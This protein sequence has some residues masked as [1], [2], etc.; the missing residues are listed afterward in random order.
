MPGCARAIFQFAGRG[1]NRDDPLGELI[2]EVNLLSD[3]LHRERLGALEASALLRTVISELD[4]NIFSFDQDLRLRLVN[5][6]GERL[7]DQPAERLLGRHAAELGLAECLAHEGARTLAM[8][9]AGQGAAPATRWEAQH[10]RFR[11]QGVAQH[12]LVLSDLSRALREEERQ[13]WQRLVRVLGHELNNSL[14]PIKSIAASLGALLVREPL[15]GDWRTDTQRG[16]E[17]IGSRAEALGRFMTAYAKLARLPRPELRSIKISP[18]L[19][20]IVALETR[21]PLILTPGQEVTVQADEGQ[22]EQLLIN[23]IRNA[24]E[25]TLEAERTAVFVRWHVSWDA[26]VESRRERSRVLEVQ[27]EDEGHGVGD[28][29][30]LFV[31]FFTTKPGGSGIGLVLSRQ[32]A[33]AHG[34]S[35]TLTDKPAS[36]GCIARL[37][38]PLS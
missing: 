4:V 1:A 21:L 30:N 13:A 5:R 29:A 28:T 16:L 2:A 7:L 27:I 26:G 20:R 8:R 24:V 33:E 23:L 14:T 12:L 9:F 37:T 10:G 25:A 19:R 11:E 22:L 6:A 3:T 17:V 15:P 34:G 36:Q 35:L 32:I 38:L 18:L 31:P